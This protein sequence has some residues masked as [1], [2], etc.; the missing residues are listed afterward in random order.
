MVLRRSLHEPSKASNPRLRSQRLLGDKAQD[1]IESA[2]EWF[3]ELP[4]PIVLAALWIAG[5][6]LVGLCALAFYAYWW[7]LQAVAGS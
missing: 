4:V 2:F 3:L 5:V 1:R 6:A 7:I